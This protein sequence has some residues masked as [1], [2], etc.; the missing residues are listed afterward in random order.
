MDIVKIEVIEKLLP[1]IIVN[2]IRSFLGDVGFYLRI[3]RD[4]SKIA[5]PLYNLLEKDVVFKFDEACLQAFE[6]LKVKLTFAPIIATLDS[7]Q[8]L[9]MMCDMSD[10]AIGVVLGQHIIKVF[11]TGCSVCCEQIYILL[12]GYQSHSSHGPFFFEILPTKEGCQTKAYQI[13]VVIARI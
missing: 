10:D 3:I 12:N 6:E 8:L 5:K 1:H 9:G 11:H 4:F 7:A 2:G 13:G